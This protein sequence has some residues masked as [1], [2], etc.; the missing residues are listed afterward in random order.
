MTIATLPAES[1][2][3]WFD[4]PSVVQWMKDQRLLEQA[5]SSFPNL[6]RRVRDWEK[7]SAVNYYTLDRYLIQL[8]RAVEE[9]P[10]EFYSAKAPSRGRPIGGGGHLTP[11]QRKEITRRARAGESPTALA[12]E[13][14][15]SA[16]TVGFYKSGVR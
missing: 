11:K 15:C 12:K 7:G 1:L 9:V 8:G 16:R 2:S 3:D 6:A 13:F 14:Q 4:G 5:E 10:E